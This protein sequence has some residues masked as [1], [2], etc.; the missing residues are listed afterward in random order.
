MKKIPAAW[1]SSRSSLAVGS[2]R[3][4]V[5]VAAM[6]LFLAS[7]CA[8][9]D[10]PAA[11][12][13]PRPTVTSSPVAPAAATAPVGHPL[14]RALERAREG[15]AHIEQNVQDYTATIIKRERINGTLREHEFMFAKIRNRK[16]E[17]GKVTVPF[18]VYLKFLKPDSIKGREVIWVEGA[19]DNKLVAHESGLLGF[20]RFYLPAEG[21]LAMMGQRYPIMEIGVQNLIEQLI[22]QG[23]RDLQYGECEVKFFKGAKVDNYSCTLI[24]VL[25]P[26]RRDHFTFYRAQIFIDDTLGVPVRYAAWTWPTEPGGEPVLEEEYTYRN[27]QLNVGLT[28]MDFDPDNPAYAF[29]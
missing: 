16:T 6:L 1:H 19:N 23:E 8:R 14:N 5:P 10:E 18:A 27:I 26:V 9:S 25:H 24:E 29:P 11:T 28:D 3:V 21:M 17:N 7:S 22:I 20:K 13:T 15:L 12:L 4:V 2:R